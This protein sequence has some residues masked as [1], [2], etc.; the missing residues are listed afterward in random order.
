[1]SNNKDALIY[2]ILKFLSEERVIASED[3]AESLE[4]AEQCLET[5]YS[6]SATDGNRFTHT[7]SLLE[8]FEAGLKQLQQIVSTKKEI[9]DAERT[10]AEQSKAEGNE[11]MREEKYP[12]ALACYT[13]SI[14]TDPTNAIYFC[15][16][17]AALS[18]LNKHDEA[19]NDCND[20]LKID[21]SYSKAYGRK[22][23]ALSSLNRHKEAKVCLEKALELDPS[24][25][26]FKQNLELVVQK[27]NQ[28]PA[29]D[30]GGMNFGG[31]DFSQIL[32]NPTLMNMATNML[33]NPQMQQMMT[34]MMTGPNGQSAGDNPENFSGLLTAGQQLAQQL[35]TANPDLV[36]QL[37][38]QMRNPDGSP[39]DGSS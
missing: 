30:M 27:L 23:L 3:V 28:M 14:E 33:Q 31:M 2:S 10:F 8:I 9:S 1:M 38:N 35:E 18:K 37:R 22:G 36:A 32:N 16:R 21:A 7:A 17:A 20:A 24:N 15:N 4:V 39:A 29:M 5:S 12:E 6:I 34:Q 11:Y 13:K 26:T 19:I 25:E